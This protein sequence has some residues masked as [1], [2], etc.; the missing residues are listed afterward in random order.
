MYLKWCSYPLFRVRTIAGSFSSGGGGKGAVM[1]GRI[2]VTFRDDS[3]LVLWATKDGT[4]VGVRR[5]F[6][7]PAGKVA[8]V[9]AQRSELWSF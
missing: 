9:T 2:V 4:A 6:D 8:N 5:H 3:A 1:A 7:R